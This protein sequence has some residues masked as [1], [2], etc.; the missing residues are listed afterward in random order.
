MKIEN[1]N[2]IVASNGPLVIFNSDSLDLVFNQSEVLEINCFIDEVII[3]NNE[4]Q[5]NTDNLLLVTTKTNFIDKLP[6]HCVLVDEDFCINMDLEIDFGGDYGLKVYDNIQ[7][8]ELEND[9]LD[10]AHDDMSSW[11]TSEMEL[12]PDKQLILSG[13]SVFV[14]IN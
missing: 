5:L 8:F 7:M 13:I 11:I 1:N 14:K 2:K 12:N 6:E 9:I 3:N 10:N 4:F